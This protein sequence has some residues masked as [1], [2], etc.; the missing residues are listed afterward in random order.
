MLI[1]SVS[2][3]IDQMPEG[4]DNSIISEYIPN[5]HHER[6]TLETSA[7]S[8]Y[9]ATRIE[10]RGLKSQCLKLRHGSLR[11]WDTSQYPPRWYIEPDQYA[12]HFNIRSG[13]SLCFIARNVEFI[14][15]CCGVLYDKRAIVMGSRITSSIPTA[16]RNN[17]NI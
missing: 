2:F 12:V 6:H 1:F 15:E 5:I 10:V 17:A 9:A 13:T 3:Q 4:R 7:S 11:R 14:S 8:A 16:R